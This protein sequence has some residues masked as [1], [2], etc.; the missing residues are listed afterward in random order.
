MLEI[1]EN[2]LIKFN[3]IMYNY[4]LLVLKMTLGGIWFQ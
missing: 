2:C 3:Y 1:R 4:K